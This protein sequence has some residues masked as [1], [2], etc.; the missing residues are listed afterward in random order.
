M[1]LMS[2]ARASLAALVPNKCGA[3]WNAY[4]WNAYMYLESQAQLEDGHQFGRQLRAAL[5]Q[6]RTLQNGV[7]VRRVC[8]DELVHG[9]GLRTPQEVFHGAYELSLRLMAGLPPLQDDRSLASEHI[10][11]FSVQDHDAV[12]NTVVVGASG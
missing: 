12:P 1:R 11:F 2:S 6:Q 4:M 10:T 8:G 3:A 9:G 7:Q 5:L